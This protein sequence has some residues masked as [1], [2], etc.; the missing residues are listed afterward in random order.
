MDW[1]GYLFDIAGLVGFLGAVYLG[2]A[3]FFRK[4]SR[5]SKNLTL[6]VYLVAEHSDNM[7]LIR[8][9]LTADGGMLPPKQVHIIT[10]NQLSEIPA[11]SI[12]VVYYVKPEGDSNLLLADVMAKK[13]SPHSIPLLVYSPDNG[14]V[15]PADRK[16]LN[17]VQA[18]ISNYPIRLMSDI[19]ATMCIFP[20]K[21]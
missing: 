17:K 6:P 10:D 19:W 9:S 16:E 5:L 3:R 15:T 13:T 2:A 20:H 21:S 4:E 14:A 8:D 11:K 18:A 1:L 7:G 12:V